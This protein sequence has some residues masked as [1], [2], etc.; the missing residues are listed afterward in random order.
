[1]LVYS[2]ASVWGALLG[3]YRIHCNIELGERVDRIVFD[4]ELGNV[5]YYVLLSN[6]Y[7]AVGKWDEVAKVRIMMKDRGLRNPPGYNMIEINNRV[8]AFIMGDI[9]HPQSEKIYAMLETLVRQ[10]KETGYVSK[11]NFLLHDVEK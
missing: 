9:S 7:A 6:M 5:G 2:N 3:A 10:I 4:L 11:T 1:M 8:H